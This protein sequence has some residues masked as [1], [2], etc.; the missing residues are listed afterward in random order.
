M[1]GMGV[2]RKHMR[3]NEKSKS[4]LT[5][6][7]SDNIY[8]HKVSLMIFTAPQC[9]LGALLLP[10]PVPGYGAGQCAA[11]HRPSQPLQQPL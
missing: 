3:P 2:I 1:F 7:V 6:T 4:Y 10:Q 8:P 5:Q 11:H 9:I